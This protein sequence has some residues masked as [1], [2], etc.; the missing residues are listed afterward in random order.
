MSIY[1]K[2]T[3]TKQD[4]LYDLFNNW[5][6]IHNVK[7]FCTDGIIDE[8]IYDKQKVKVLFIANES[9]DKNNVE[10]LDSNRIEDFR[11]YY[12]NGYDNW[13]GK[14]RERIC[15]LYQVVI[16]NYSNKVNKCAKNFAFM[17]L[18]K[19][20][21]GNSIGDGEHIYEFCRKY[22][23]QIKNEIEIINPDIV[24]WLG[25]N[26]FKKDII[27]TFLSAEK[28]DD[29]YYLSI[30]EKKVPIIGTWH[31][32]YTRMPK[33]CKMLDKFTDEKIKYNKVICKLYIPTS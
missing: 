17:N 31:T 1:T 23:I 14:M 25:I 15:C 3:K 22:K 32:S 19:S 16:D 29:I 30:G 33:N 27:T 2:S 24:I 11:C 6:K 9:N 26:T 28:Q 21:G 8:N 10:H 4:Q 5:K 13:K 12:E 7:P 18:N 20:G